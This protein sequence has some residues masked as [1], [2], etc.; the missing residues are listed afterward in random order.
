MTIKK[1]AIEYRLLPFIMKYVILVIC[2]VTSSAIAGDNDFIPE[3]L[4]GRYTLIGK[5]PDSGV[6]Y[7][8]KVEIYLDNGV[9]KVFRMIGGRTVTGDA[10]IEKVL[11]GDAD[12]LRIRFKEGDT[13]YEE[14]CLWHGDLDNYARISC[15]LY[16]P[17]E[18]VMNPGLEALFID[19]ATR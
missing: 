16:K 7:T 17:G 4:A 15:Y 2:F 12:V 8:G 10:A 11:D 1:Y 6:P 18:K 9:L 19:H 3:F 14:T 13:G 5:R